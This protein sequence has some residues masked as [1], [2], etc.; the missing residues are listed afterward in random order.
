MPANNQSSSTNATRSSNNNE[1]TDNDATIPGGGGGGAVPGTATP[2]NISLSTDDV[3]YQQQLTKWETTWK[4]FNRELRDPY[5]DFNALGWTMKLLLSLVSLGIYKFR[6]QKLVPFLRSSIPMF[7]V[8]LICSV[9][10]SYILSIRTNVVKKRWCY[11]RDVVPEEK[12]E[13]DDNVDTLMVPIPWGGVVVYVH[14]F[15]VMYLSGMILFHYLSAVFKSPGVALSSKYDDDIRRRRRRRHDCND[16]DDDDDD[17]R[18]QSPPEGLEWTATRSQGGMLCLDP[19]LDVIQERELTATYMNVSTSI[20]ATT[21]TATT[22]TETDTST[23]VSA[24]TPANQQQHVQTQD[25]NKSHCRSDGAARTGLDTATSFPSLDRT[26]CA[27]CNIWRPARCHHCS[28]CDRC[29]LQFDHHC[30]WLNNCVGYNNYRHFL[31][32]LIFLTAG[33]W[34]GI[35]ILY[36]PFY[37]PLKRSLDEYGWK[38]VL[39]YGGSGDDDSGGSFLGIPTFKSLIHQLRSGTA[40]LS[41]SPVEDSDVIVNIVFPLLASVGLIQVV[42]LSYHIVYVCSAMTTLEYSMLTQWRYKKIFG[43]DGRNENNQ[44]TFSNAGDRS[45]GITETIFS[46]PI[47]PPNPFDGGW[48]NNL[49]NVLGPIQYIFIPLYFPPTPPRTTTATPIAEAEAAEQQK[50]K[51]N[52]TKKEP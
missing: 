28:V 29:V 42:F 6:L 19:T 21:T 44:K 32:T 27:K 36:K 33:C 43:D 47:P 14:D 34:Y 8:V 15:I 17:V 49:R 41:S 50:K 9:I 10:S 5:S 37:E 45:N 52:T 46:M 12:G 1:N 18:K 3:E 48:M 51:I 11:R 7:A 24:T 13:E 23:T 26:F 40:S 25:Q 4:Q 2:T 30:G 35:V 20:C 39:F 22:T 38:S 16:D 31:L